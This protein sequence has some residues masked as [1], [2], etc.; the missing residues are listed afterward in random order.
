MILTTPTAINKGLL[1]VSIAN[2]SI[3]G[4]TVAENSRF[5]RSLGK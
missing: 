4:G 1:S 3:S 2:C 5:C